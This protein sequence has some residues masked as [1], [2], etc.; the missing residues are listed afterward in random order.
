MRG[1][2]GQLDSDRAGPCLAE[3]KDQGTEIKIKRHEA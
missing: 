2:C 3:E 1:S